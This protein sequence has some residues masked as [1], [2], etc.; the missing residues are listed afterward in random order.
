MKI[1]FNNLYE[2]FHENKLLSQHQSG[3]RSGDSCISQLL[4]I[5]HEI[6]SSFD[7]NPSYETRGVF[8]DMSKAFDKVWHKG[9]LFK[10]KFYG[11]EGNLLNILENYLSDREQ[12]V[13]L[14][15]QSSSWLGVNAGV[16]VNLDSL[17]IVTPPVTLH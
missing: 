17:G 4:A 9:L 12:R 5:T 7:G 16:A 15:G 13:I 1:I 14:C 3:F 6:Y 10:L 11:V 2:I 8:L